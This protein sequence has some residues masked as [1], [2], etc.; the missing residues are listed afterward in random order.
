MVSSPTDNL[1][2]LATLAEQELSR[3][4]ENSAVRSQ[5]VAGASGPMVDSTDSIKESDSRPGSPSDAMLI[6]RPDLPRLNTD[7]SDNDVESDQ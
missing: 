7:T 6:R 5:S 3:S 4:P 1:D 2:A